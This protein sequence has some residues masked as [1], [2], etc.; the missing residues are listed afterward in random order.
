MQLTK[1]KM[2]ILALTLVLCVAV[3]FAAYWIYSTVVHV[4][5]TPPPYT[6]TLEAAQTG[7]YKITLTATLT[8]QHFGAQQAEPVSDATIHF[9]LTDAEGTTKEEIGTALTGEDGVAI[10]V[11]DV[12][13]PQSQE[14]IDYY[15]IAGYEVTG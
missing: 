12:P 4:P 6:V 5:Y 1:K 3:A 2:A 9:Y 13:F 15:F 7:D 11:W 8:V 10:Y 14:P